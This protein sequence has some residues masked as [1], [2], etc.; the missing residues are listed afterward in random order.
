VGEGEAPATPDPG[1]DQGLPD[2][3]L[4]L[5]ED[6]TPASGAGTAAP[7]AGGV[8]AAGDVEVT[9]AKAVP[10][11]SGMLVKLLMI[12]GAGFAAFKIGMFDNIMMLIDVSGSEPVAP[13]VSIKEPIESPD[14]S[15]PIQSGSDAGAPIGQETQDPPSGDGGVWQDPRMA[16][17][18]EDATPKPA[19][20]TP[21]AQEE[22]QEEQVYAEEQEGEWFFEGVVYDMISLKPVSGAEML[23]MD[24]SE[25]ET[26]DAVTNSRGRYRV[27]L[28]SMPQGYKL[29]VDH[30]DYL[31]MYFDEAA[32]S[33]RKISMSKRKQLRAARPKNAP[34]AG[35]IGRKNRRDIVLF[36]EIPDQN[37]RPKA[38][39]PILEEPF[40]DQ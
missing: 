40:A 7:Q 20:N 9:A 37:V 24:E 38:A 10:Q 22:V 39:K 19:E 23:F 2:H 18:V 17:L 36:P 11:R 31:G 6:E 3:I 28:P 5:G 16:E 12:G 34:W 32:P 8:A 26:Y 15:E 33:Y 1:A 21:V 25:S 13:V 30:R 14:L 27:R 29:I 35:R 4:D